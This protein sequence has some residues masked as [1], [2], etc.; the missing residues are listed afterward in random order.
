MFLKSNYMNRSKYYKL[1][2]NLIILY[3]LNLTDLFFT[4]YLLAVEPTMFREANI[5]LEPIINGVGPYFLKIILVGG[6]LYYWYFMSRKSD[7][8]EMNRS[9]V[10][11]I[12]LLIVYLGINILHLFNL[13][14]MFYFK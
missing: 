10:A 2:I 9:L 4:K 12:G 11:S 1:K 5:F 6:V 8:K 3:I 13:F 7:D 14:I